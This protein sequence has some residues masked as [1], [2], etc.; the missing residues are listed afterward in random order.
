MIREYKL[1]LGA[2]VPGD[3]ISWSSGPGRRTVSQNSTVSFRDETQQDQIRVYVDF[4]ETDTLPLV[5]NGNFVVNVYVEVQTRGS[6]GKL[7]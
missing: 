1:P 3:V 4:I 6:F 2:V 7:Q 5:A